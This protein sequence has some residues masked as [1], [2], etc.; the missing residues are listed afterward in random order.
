M[1]RTAALISLLLCPR[2][3]FSLLVPDILTY[4]QKLKIIYLDIYGFPLPEIVNCHILLNH[5]R[6][7]YTEVQSLY[8]GFTI[9]AYRPQVD[10]NLKIPTYTTS[11]YY[12]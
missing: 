12:T 5:Q 4:T 7:K 6:L 11:T 10:T 1:T 3:F 2:S 9:K 8:H